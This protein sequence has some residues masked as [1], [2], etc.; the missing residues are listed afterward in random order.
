MKLGHFEKSI[1]H[2]FKDFK[3]G[4]EE[5]WKISVKPIV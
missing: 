4:A 5:G 1:I 2:R 3:C